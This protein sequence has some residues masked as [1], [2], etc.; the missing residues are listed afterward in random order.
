L[1]LSI[2]GADKRI[3]WADLI[4]T[5]EGCFDSQS[6]EGKVPIGV[7]RRAESLG[8]PVVIL[9]GVLGHEYIPPNNLP[10]VCAV[11][12]IIDRL[13]PLSQTLIDARTNL[14]RTA[15]QVIQTLYLGKKI[16]ADLRDF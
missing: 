5:G 10:A 4:I 7:A 13:A 9:C 11:F 14:A 12:P 3:E 16:A 8:K 2:T 15:S 6:L 1:I